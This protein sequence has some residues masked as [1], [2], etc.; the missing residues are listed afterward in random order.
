MARLCHRAGRLVPRARRALPFSGRVGLGPTLGLLLGALVLS[1]CTKR[2]PVA[3]GA[4][5]NTQRVLITFKDGRELR[6]KIDRE[7]TVE[8]SEA[9]IEYRGTVSNVNDV[10]IVLRDLV[11]VQTVGSRQEVVERMADSRLYLAAP[12]E[13]VIL[14]RVDIASV[15]RVRADGP[16]IG[17]A[18][19]FWTAA[20]VVAVLILRERS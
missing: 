15:E 6:G 4:F 9:G 13:E 2:V 18:A 3:D 10:Q 14:D 5:E 11:K 16:R 7:G 1:G 20:G 8:Y 12:R 19:G 17:R